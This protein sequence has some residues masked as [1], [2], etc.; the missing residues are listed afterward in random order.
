VLKVKYQIS[1]SPEVG[2]QILATSSYLDA[3]REGLGVEIEKEIEAVLASIATNP[4]LYPKE[5]GPVR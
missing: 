5:F 3:I 1:I 4:N 2:S